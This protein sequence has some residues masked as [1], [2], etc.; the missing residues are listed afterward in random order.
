MKARESID[1]CSG[2]SI[3]FGGIE[4]INRF[5]RGSIAVVPSLFAIF[6]PE[7]TQPQKMMH[8]VSRK[9][10]V[11]VISVT[12]LG[13]GIGLS[14]SNA[15]QAQVPK[16][17]AKAVVGADGQINEDSLKAF[18]TWATAVSAEI[19]DFAAGNAL[20]AAIY[21]TT[22]DYRSGDNIYLMYLADNAGTVVFHPGN[23]DVEGK[24]ALEVTDDEGTEVIKKMLAAGTD[25]AVRVEYC[26]NDP[27]DDSDNA[28][29]ATCKPSFAMRYFA[30]TI[31]IDLVVVGGYYQDLSTLLTPL[32]NIPLPDVSAAD[33]VDD[34]T[35]KQFVEGSVLW[36][37][38]LFDSLGFAGVLHWRTELRKDVKDG[39]FF[40]DGLVYLYSMTPDG[41]VVFHGLDAWREGRIVTNNP[42]I[43]GDTTFVRR[44]IQEAQSGGGFVDY[45]WDN[46]DD[47]NDDQEGTLRRAYGI[48]FSVDSVPEEFIFA[49]AYFPSLATSAEGTITELPTEF[50]LHGNYPNPFNPSTRIQ[51]DLPQRAHVT[52][53]VMDLLGRRVIELPAQAFAAGANQTIELN[54]GHL[55]SGTYM[56]R[57]IATGL[58]SRHEKTGLMTLVK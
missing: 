53:R 56:Y 58:E 40:K 49:G 44:I 14:E 41:Y 43:R 46:P 1:F 24:A 35:L 38:Q 33:V 19:T 20:R 23:R 28:P 8:L 36:S 21:D 16:V 45:Y 3:F 27:N 48:S 13:T 52:L 54:A 50:T 32:P 4:T 30:P 18:V 5:P 17:T 29:G 7:L 37:A 55:A 34:E 2:P 51:F 57:M 11:T 39:G 6:R 15:V 12:L 31:N 47:P 25:E 22:G 10:L 42:D 26:W 9:L